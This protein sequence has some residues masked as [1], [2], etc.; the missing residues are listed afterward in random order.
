MLSG[1]GRCFGYLTCFVASS[2]PHPFREHTASCAWKPCGHLRPDLIALASRGACFG[3]SSNA[4]LIPRICSWL[5]GHAATVAA[6]LLCLLDSHGAAGVVSMNNA[7]LECGLEKE[8]SAI[9][10]AHTPAVPLDANTR[11]PNTHFFLAQLPLVMRN[12]DDFF[13][14]F[15][16][17]QSPTVKRWLGVSTRA[18]HSASIQ[19]FA[20]HWPSTGLSCKAFQLWAKANSF[21]IK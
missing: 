20:C 13:G 6:L 17:V 1:F 16:L 4:H 21:N 19:T 14:A 7:I 18:P 10:C 9:A 5:Q 2:A 12:L 3:E 15:C 11:C 8:A